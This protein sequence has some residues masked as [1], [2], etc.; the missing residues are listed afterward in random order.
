[1]LY[2]TFL[3]TKKATHHPKIGSLKTAIEEEWN[4]MS[5]ESIFKA[6]KSFRRPV[7]TIKMATILSKLTVFCQSWNF[8]VCCIF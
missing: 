2:G 7:D 1:M 4:K 6:F 5:E 8:V 3:E